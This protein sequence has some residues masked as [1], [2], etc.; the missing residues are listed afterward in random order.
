M[1]KIRGK[2]AYRACAEGVNGRDTR[3]NRVTEKGRPL[4][5]RPCLRKAQTPAAEGSSMWTLSIVP[6]PRQTSPS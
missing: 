2:T 1:A 6:P 3:N 4:R 5:E